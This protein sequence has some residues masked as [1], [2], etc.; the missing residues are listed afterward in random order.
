MAVVHLSINCSCVFLSSA[1]T[2]KFKDSVYCRFGGEVNLNDH[3]TLRLGGGAMKSATNPEYDSA[4]VVP[5]GLYW[6]GSIGFGYRQND[7]SVDG[8]YWYSTADKKGKSIFTKANLLAAQEERPHK[9]AS[10]SLALGFNY[11]F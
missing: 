6:H 4:G 8:S 11:A 7:W 9:V 1:I 5:A 3:Y 10:H 2:V